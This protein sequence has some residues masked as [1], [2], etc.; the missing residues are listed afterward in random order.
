[1]VVFGKGLY[2]SLKT[3]DRS[4]VGTQ[5]GHLYL[6]PVFPIASYV[7]LDPDEKRF[8][9]IPIPLDGRSVLAAY[10]RVASVF[11]CIASLAFLLAGQGSKV[12]WM[13]SWVCGP[14]AL[15]SGLV[16]VWSLGFL[17]RLSAEDHQRHLAYRTTLGYAIDPADI[18]V[19]APDFDLREKT[20]KRLLARMRS[21]TF[22]GYRRAVNPSRDWAEVACDPS[23]NDQEL[24]FLALV[25]ARFLA[26]HAE[27]AGDREAMATAHDRI[28]ARVRDAKWDVW[29]RFRPAKKAKDLS[30]QLTGRTAGRT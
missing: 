16:A 22:Q 17:G 27:D 23:V 30:A 18:P 20:R 2:G 7:V 26:F 9:G 4:F 29:Q 28:W 14:V 13:G 1:M 5:F 3:V 12:P 25:Y 19:G 10:V 24:V 11:V 21:L 15:F 6:V 8:K